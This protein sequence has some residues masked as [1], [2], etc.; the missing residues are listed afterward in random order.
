MKSKK[1]KIK[2]IIGWREWVD[3]PDLAIVQIK[4]KS[5]T[6]AATSSL[7]AYDIVELENGH[8]QFKVHPNQHD[9]ETVVCCEALFFEKRPIKSSN[10]QTEVRYLIQTSL[11]ISGHKFH[12]ELSLSNRSDMGFRLLLGREF[13]SQG[14]LVDSRRSFLSLKP[15]FND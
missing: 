6:G 11:V 12:I 15:G 13:L 3:L 8:L 1:I 2:K 14:F 7:H 4:A 9:E 5:D 10:G